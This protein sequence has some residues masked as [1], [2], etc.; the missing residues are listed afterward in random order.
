MLFRSRGIGYKYAH[1]YP[2][3]YVD[4]Q[5]LPDPYVGMKLYNPGELGLEKERKTWLDR[6]RTQEETEE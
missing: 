5:Y 3:H 6:I 2:N 4:Q 1:D